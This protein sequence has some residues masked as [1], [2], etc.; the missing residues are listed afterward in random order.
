MGYE[1]HLMRWPT[2]D[3]RRE[4]VAR[5]WRLLAAAHAAVGG[6]V[7]SGGGTGTCDVNTVAHR[8]PGRLLHADGRRTTR[9][10]GLPFRPALAS[11]A[12]VISVG[13]RLG[14]R[15]LPG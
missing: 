13:R 10:R 6:D 12:T 11:S 7:V 3:E 15:R 8:A 2:R 4:V 9:A 1:G 14:R 5:P